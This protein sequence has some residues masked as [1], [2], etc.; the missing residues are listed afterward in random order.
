MSSIRK[1]WQRHKWQEVTLVRGK[2]KVPGSLI[3]LNCRKAV[4]ADEGDPPVTG[5]PIDTDL[6]KA[7]DSRLR[8]QR[9]YEMKQRA[10]NEEEERRRYGG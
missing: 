5:C 7:S 4:F 6:S 9:D 8:E 3:C 2:E 10:R 1:E